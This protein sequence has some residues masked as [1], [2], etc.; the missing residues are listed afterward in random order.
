VYL[1]T[2][3]LLIRDLE[4][5]DIPALVKLWTDPD[6]TCYMGGPRDVTGLRKSLGEDAGAIPPAFDLRP[7]VDKA[8]GEVV[9]HCGLLEKLVDGAQEIELVY[10]FAK[11]TW[12]RGLATEAARALR[13][14]AFDEMRIPRLIALIDPG[15][16]A[17]ARVAAKIGLEYEKSTLRSGGK[18][19]QVYALANPAAEAGS[20]SDKL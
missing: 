18:E 11:A 2:Q 12:G 9:G 19:M 3:R 8:S 6:V 15:N 5:D 4:A 14:H 20:P 16:A 17:S 10:V 1:E 13:D 7:V